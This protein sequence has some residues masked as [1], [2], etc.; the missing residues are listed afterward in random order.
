M[1]EITRHLSMFKEARMTQNK[2]KTPGGLLLISLL[3]KIGD[4]YRLRAWRN[5]CKF[6]DNPLFIHY[7]VFK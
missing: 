5:H 3:L 7:Y 6:Y 4:G 2:K 1:A